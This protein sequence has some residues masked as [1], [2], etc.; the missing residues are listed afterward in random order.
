M[1]TRDEHEIQSENERTFIINGLKSTPCIRTDGREMMQQRKISIQF[2]RNSSQSQASL[3]LGNTRVLANVHGE[4]VTPFPDRPTEGFFNT[5]VDLSPMASQNFETGRPSSLSIEL[6]KMID[7]SIRDC[8]AFD[9]EALA[10]L[11]GEKVWAIYCEVHVIDHDGNLTDAVQIASIAA[12]MHFRRPDLSLELQKENEDIKNFEAYD[13]IPL[14]LHHIP[15]SVSFSYMLTR[16]NMDKNDGSSSPL[17]FMDPTSREE[18]VMNGVITF[19]FNS[20]RE[21]CAVHK[22]GGAPISTE[23]ILRCAQIAAARVGELVSVLKVEERKADESASARQR[24]KL[25]G[26][27][28][29]DTSSIH[30]Q[31]SMAT[32]TIP[33]DLGELTDFSKMHMRIPLGGNEA[34][35]ETRKEHVSSMAELLEVLEMTT[36]IQANA[37]ALG[38]SRR[39]AHSF[40]IDLRYTSKTEFSARVSDTQ[41]DQSINRD[42]LEMVDSSEEDEPMIVKSEFATLPVPAPLNAQDESSDEEDHD[43]LA[44]VRRNKC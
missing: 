23:D 26:R 39:K 11:A 32:D 5:S 30:Y 44:A 43:L 41:M 31:Q 37:E 4:I 19:I 28:F 6:A 33:V 2:R 13:T 29:L 18:Q 8:R 7:R 12:L 36:G 22:N 9:T 34:N 3:C 20:F 42:A 10:I 38:D 1:A 15:L 14:S 25:R 35:D 21:L 24:A 27:N 40:G 16:D 17:F